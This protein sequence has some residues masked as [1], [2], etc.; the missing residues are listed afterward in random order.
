M[1]F[2]KP[3][4][5]TNKKEQLPEAI[6]A[7]HRESD[8]KK[9]CEI[10]MEAFF[11]EVR[12]AALEKISDPKLLKDI[13]LAQNTSYEIRH[14]AVGRISQAAVLAEIAVQR[15]AYPADGE[16]VARL[17]DPALLKMIALSEQGGEQDKAVYKITDQR[18]LAEIAIHA[19]K[20][21][22]RKTAI[23]NIDD[24]DILMDIIEA[25]E[26]GYT[27]TESHTR[28]RTLLTAPQ[29]QILS[30]EQRERYMDLI[31]NEQDRGVH[32]DLF[33]FQNSRD[34]E[35]IFQNAA[36]YDLKAAA[37][38]CLVLMEDYSPDSLLSHWKTA[39]EREKSVHNT[40]ANPWQDARKSIEDRLEIE[41]TN[42]PS[43]LL[44]FVRDD[45]VES[46]Y[47]AKCVGSLFDEKFDTYDEIETLRDESFA[48]FLRNIPAYARRD[49]I[50]DVKTYLLMLTEAIPPAFRD[51]CGLSVFAEEYGREEN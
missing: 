51:R 2:L 46:A 5:K 35:R 47:A 24:P 1:Q 36:R 19:K 44:D 16:A 21:S 12:S 50:D 37:L 3:I 6:T 30:E 10:V 43:L 34:F 9:L 48:A 14:A 11:P 7:V 4:W 8:P 29:Q 13:I 26:E 40:Y 25:S 15:Q 17:S 33:Y 42:R 18:D 28:I 39:E 31:I 49:G 20:G 45:A 32:I 41:E 38:S 22:A 23:R 27:R